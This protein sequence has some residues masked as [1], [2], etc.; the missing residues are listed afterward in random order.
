MLSFCLIIRENFMHK[1]IMMAVLS[2]V[3]LQL[4]GVAQDN[5]QISPQSV[6]M[7]HLI[8]LF[9]FGGTPLNK[10]T[11]AAR[12]A[13]IFV[14]HGYVVGY[15]EDRRNPLW[16]A[17]MASDLATPGEP[18]RFERTGF[19]FPDTR[20][21]SAVGGQTFGGGFDRG[22]MTPNFAIAS[23]YGSL[24][25]LETFLMTNISPQK[26]DLNQSTWANL[27]KFVVEAA[28]KLEHVYVIS[29]PIFGSN[30]S[31]VQNVPGRR[32]QIPDAFYMILV[33]TDNEHLPQPTVRMI[34]YRFPQNTERNADF[35]DRVRFGVSVNQIEAETKLDF[36]PNLNQV[37]G[38]W[39]DREN[40]KVM[41]HWVL[42]NN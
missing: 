31:T 35:R 38:D 29:G 26:A 7:R 20:S 18:Q 11:A 3:L 30:P 4:S 1:K 17:Y 13:V 24:A 40:V 42:P 23:Q 14:N 10:D 21:S 37:F 15:S 22:H 34:A 9:M 5:S 8:N 25:Q 41:Q 32:I 33:D 16:S 36:F 28:Q 39:E 27:E 2:L 12:R 6:Q 19:F